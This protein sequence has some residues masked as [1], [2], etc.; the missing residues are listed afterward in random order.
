MQPMLSVQGCKQRGRVA[1]AVDLAE[2]AEVSAVVNDIG[3]ASV[4][5]RLKR[6][7]V[8]PRV[9]SST[10]LL[11]PRL[12]A[13]WARARQSQHGRSHS[14]RRSTLWHCEVAVVAAME[15]Q[16]QQLTMASA[17]ATVAAQQQC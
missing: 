16:Q 13:R 1:V 5:R 8:A 12:V 11:L 4:A 3:V 9:R 7:R 2:A 10:V 14:A 17:G 15:V 6:A